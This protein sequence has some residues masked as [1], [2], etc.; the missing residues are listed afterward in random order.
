MLVTC[1]RHA[2]NRHGLLILEKQ[3][4]EQRYAEEKHR[5]KSLETKLEQG[6]KVTLLTYLVKVHNAYYIC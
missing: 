1:L 4:L 3:A 2:C 6:S 5:S